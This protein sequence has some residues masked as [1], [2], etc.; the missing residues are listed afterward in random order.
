MGASTYSNVFLRRNYVGTLK[1][2]SEDDK[3]ETISDCS[4]EELTQTSNWLRQYY[5]EQ[6]ILQRAAHT[7]L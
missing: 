3:A 4:R 6:K 2:S 5:G 7:F 1:S